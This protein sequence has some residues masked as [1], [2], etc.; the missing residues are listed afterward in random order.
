MVCQVSFSQTC[1]LFKWAFILFMGSLQVLQPLKEKISQCICFVCY[2]V[3]RTPV[4]LAW[5]DVCAFGQPGSLL[6]S[7]SIW[8]RFKMSTTHC[9]ESCPLLARLS[10]CLE[11]KKHV[12]CS[13]SPV[14]LSDT[15]VLCSLC[16]SQLISRST[17]LQ[18]SLIHF[19]N[20]TCRCQ[21]GAENRKFL[22]K[23]SLMVKSCV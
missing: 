1:H 13:R 2:R 11:W 7:C 15:Q 23:K 8:S 18:H 3:H 4:S 5:V 20:T 14:Q 12:L 21:K 16:W 22:N 9:E 10:L 6:S 19:F 17:W